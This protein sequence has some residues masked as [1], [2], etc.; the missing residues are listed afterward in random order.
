MTQST[1]SGKLNMEHRWGDRRKVIL[2]IRLC[3]PDRISAIGWLTDISL[4]GAYVRTMAPVAIMSRIDIEVD[5]RSSGNAEPRRLQL[6]G[7]VVRHGP[8]GI[9]VEWQ[10]FASPTLGE[11]LQ[12]AA[13]IPRRI[14][15]TREGA[16]GP[17]LW[18]LAM[19]GMPDEKLC[20]I[21]P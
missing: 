19:Y 5:E 11:V 15:Q 6:Q 8:R 16:Q 18:S 21:E 1:Y 20:G 7:R 10:E 17:G 13:R 4:S 3:G 9:G 2:R 12:I 14:V